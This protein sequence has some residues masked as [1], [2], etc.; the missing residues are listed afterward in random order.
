MEARHCSRNDVFAL[1]ENTRAPSSDAASLLL[2]DP[3]RHLVAD[4]RASLEA[5]LAAL[6]EERLR[7]HFLCGYLSYEAGS[8]LGDRPLRAPLG[9]G[10]LLDFYAFR[11]CT[12]W[13]TP[14]VEE[15][16]ASLEP[17]IPE[18]VAIHDFS[19]NE[20]NQSYGAKIRTIKERIR[21]GDTYQV[22]FT[23]QCRFGHEGSPLA[24]YRAL[25][26]RQRVEFGGYLNFP[27]RRILSFSPELFIRKVGDRLTSKPMKGTAPRGRSEEED[28]ATV[29]GLKSDPKTMS[30]NL[31][32]VDL[33]RN[34]LGRLAA[35]G[36]V[37]VDDLFEVQTFETVHQMISTVRAV[38]PP[39]VTIGRVFRELF[40][41][42]SITGA[43][44][45]RTMEIIQDLEVSP[46]GVYTG[47]LGYVTPTNDFCFAV[48]IRTV[49]CEHPGQAHM[50]IG[51]GIIDESDPDA[52]F[53]ECLLKARFVTGL[54]QH[55]QL[56][57]SMRFEGGAIADLEAHLAR[58]EASARSFQFGCDVGAIRAALERAV[59][60]LRDGVHKVRLLLAQ[61]GQVEVTAEEIA[62]LA[63]TDR[64]FVVLS[65]RRTDSRSCFQYHKT[66]RRRL[67]EEE[68]QRARALGAHD[69]LFLNERDE[70]AE[71]SRHNVFLRKEGRLLTPPVQA[72]ILPGVARRRLLDDPA[73]GAAE[74]TLRLDDLAAATGVYLTNSVRGVVE[75]AVRLPPRSAPLAKEA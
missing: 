13:S 75:V 38:V 23:L 68:F 71:G 44:K 42:G 50:G 61:S 43:P 63:P 10:P 26:R 2:F 65:D 45:V 7:G 18:Q 36:S 32:I 33:I 15:W 35:L 34:D 27:D 57:E 5:G 51:S 60:P 64:P 74:A 17:G 49:V 6:E 22:N 56:I 40:P 54:N 55:F 19:L 24:L 52:E 16:L 4:D 29:E 48:P 69:V 11:G 37:A 8:F 73:V 21:D 12:R 67:Y 58:L 46:R 9:A 41:C 3:V 62:A 30:E 39:D 20:T 28:R 47:A 59:A 14:A 53:A 70:L 66:T 25:R 1:L 72:G 31:M